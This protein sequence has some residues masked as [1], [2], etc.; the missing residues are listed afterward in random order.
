MR[1]LLV[2]LCTFAVCALQTYPAFSQTEKPSDTPQPESSTVA[3]FPMLLEVCLEATTEGIPKDSA[4]EDTAVENST[5][6]MPSASV[7]IVGQRSALS[8]EVSAEMPSYY[9]LGDAH[10]RVIAEDALLEI[11]TLPEEEFAQGVDLPSGSEGREIVASPLERPPVRLLQLET[12]NQLIARALQL[13]FGSHQT[14]S[15]DTPGTG[16]QLYYGEV[17]WGVTDDLQVSLSGQVYDDP[18]VRA[19]N[20]KFQNITLLSLASSVKYRLLNGE[21]LALSLQGALEVLSVSS[22]LFGTRGSG[23]SN[24]AGSIHVPLTYTASPDLQ[25]HFTPGVSFLPGQ[26]NDS[27]FY[28]TVFTL[29]TGANWQPS[30]RW[31]L[32]S[33]LNLPLGPGGNTIEAD[34][35]IDRQLVWS[36]GTRYSVTPRTGVNLYATN[37]LGATPST[38]V[39]TAAPGGDELLVGVELQYTPDTGLGYRDRFDDE[40][41]PTLSERDLQLLVN[42]ITLASANTLAPGNIAVTAG[43][44]TQGQFDVGL[45]Y[46]PDEALQ[47]EANVEDF[48]LGDRTTAAA[49]DSLRYTL[50]ARVQLLDQRRGAP[51][52]LSARILG[53]RDTEADGT[54]GVLFTDLPMAY[55]AG[56]R[57]ALL[58]NPRAAFSS[59][60]TRLGLGF[61]INYEVVRGLQ[62]MG[63]VTPVFGGNRMVWGLGSRYSFPNAVSL[64]IYATNALGRHG[65]GTLVS[66]SEVRLGAGI[67]WVL[68]R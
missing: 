4:V 10:C 41:S 27:K 11:Q 36:V 33:T 21:Q 35:T 60:D 2:T 9:L 31:L 43:A 13:S 26:L 57:V 23:G 14:L 28:D 29:G 1:V 67:N 68:G 55:E 52:S 15:D 54:T 6:L 8:S 66:G 44:G 50:G 18:P 47:L 17:D 37:G 63:E 25:F 51:I 30:D 48:G 24:L 45:A 3:A 39:L 53:G 34:Q 64:D 38:A 59:G 61:G 7:R 62:L 58:F 46:S 32:Y 22:D 65:L 20:G 12:A 40:P 19:I 49:S 5:A 16:S 42:G 56:E